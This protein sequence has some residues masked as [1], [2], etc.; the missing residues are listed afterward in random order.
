MKSKVLLNILVISLV[1]IMGSIISSS[2]AEKTV[3]EVWTFVNPIGED[4]RSM[5][6]NHIRE[7]FE[8]K[9]PDIEVKVNVVSW[10]EIDPMLLRAVKAGVAPDVVEFYQP[11]FQLHVSA[12]TIQPLDRFVA[13]WSD[14]QKNDFLVPWETTIVNGHKY[15]FNYEHRVSGMLYRKDILEKEGLKKPNSLQ[16]LGEIAGKLNNPPKLVGFSRGMNVVDALGGIEFAIP[17]A[18][19]EGGKLINEDGTAAFNSPAWEKTLQYWVD[20]VVGKYKAMPLDVALGESAEAFDLVLSGLSVFHPSLSHRIQH[21]QETSGLGEKMGFMELPSF[22]EGKPSPMY[23]QGWMLAIPEGAKNPEAAWKYIEHFVSTESQAYLSEHCGYL[24][25]RKSVIDTPWF[26]T[27]EA[28]T[29]RF[30]LELFIR[31]DVV[32]IVIPEQF[33]EISTYIGEAFVKAI[34]QEASPKEALTEAA[35][36]WNEKFAR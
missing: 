6:H 21:A 33:T 27:P 18:A 8:E 25:V 15:S 4:V 9:Y 30:L 7:S 35:N 12:G 29:M 24:P 16:E 14:E 36:K 28:E 26:D 22:K 20:L 2:A 3:I 11:S 34:R 13:D 10:K 32:S 5:A 17:I 31:S 23:S 1:L 19:S